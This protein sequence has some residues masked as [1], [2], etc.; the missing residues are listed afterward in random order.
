MSPAKKDRLR[1][2]VI[3]LNGKTLHGFIAHFS[4]SM[5]ELPLHTKHGRRMIL[6]DEI[7]YILFQHAADGAMLKSQLPNLL[8]V[9]ITT[10]DGKIY[11]AKIQKTEFNPRGFHAFPVHTDSTFA[12]AYFFHRGVCLVE[13]AKPLGDIL[14][15]EKL[16]G[17]ENVQQALDKQRKGQVPL[18]HILLES[19]KLNEQ[20]LQNSLKRQQWMRAKLGE[21]LIE[22]GHINSE[23]LEQALTEQRKRHDK[24]LGDLLIEMGLI[25][26]EALVSALSIKFHLPL[27]NLD[28][29]PI[30]DDAHSELQEDIIMRYQVLPIDIDETTLTVATADPLDIDAYD[31]IRF[32]TN[33]RIRQVIAIPSQLRQYID[34]LF[35]SGRAEDWLEID[36]LHEEEEDEETEVTQLALKGS[37]AVPIVRLVNKIILEGLRKNASDIHILPQADKTILAY[38]INGELL[39]ETTLDKWHEK[40]VVARLKILSGM[41]VTVHRMPQDGRMAVR[42]EHLARELR[43]SCIPNAHGESIVMR[44][45]HRESSAEL[46]TLGLRG[47]DQEALQRQ[48]LRPFGL[49]LA[50][51]PTGSGKST[52]LFALLKSIADT[53][54]HILTIEDPIEMEIPGINQIQVNSRIGMSFSRILRNVLRHDP[55]VVMVGEMRDPETAE[56]GIQAALTGHLMLSSLH[57]NTA[58]DTVVRLIDLGI[59]AYLLASALNAV[60]SQNLVRKLC[61]NC[62]ISLPV[63]SDIAKLL[64]QTNMDIPHRLYVPGQCDACHGTGFIGRVMVYELLELNDTMRMAIHDGL[65]GQELEK[66]AIQ[67]GMVPKTRHA[68]ELATAGE[69]CR[70][71]LMHLLI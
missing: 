60:I 1:V 61:P 59:P 39:Q 41:D 21:V 24:R 32:H 49:I 22:S 33:R 45:L 51:G 55:D 52:T 35:A 11:R 28:E 16:T 6:L 64:Q 27:V 9:R 70:D 10:F 71:D 68:Y 53:P 44:I 63:D 18:G 8:E 14:V 15:A 67:A 12:H 7:A 65:V 38:R 69:I 4:P 37:E 46:N 19:G 29:Y 17:K 5:N 13:Y 34:D 2:R 47:Q 40:R 42:H 30:N 58:V 3:L 48:M 66:L 25:T 20:D 23:E 43:I 26:E 54:K 36:Q 50:T 56:I 62:R 57:T 31:A